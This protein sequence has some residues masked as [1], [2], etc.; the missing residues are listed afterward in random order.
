MTNDKYDVTCIYYVHK[1]GTRKLSE[2]IRESFYYISVAFVICNF[3]D[4]DI[5]IAL[6]FTLIPCK[7]AFLCQINDLIPLLTIH[8]FSLKRSLSYL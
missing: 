4:S 6:Q 8:D 3:L 1:G 7:S 5:A 2:F